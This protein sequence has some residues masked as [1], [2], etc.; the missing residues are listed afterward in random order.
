MAEKMEVQG[1]STGPVISRV[2][3]QFFI[4]VMIWA[5]LLFWS[6]GTLKWVRGWI[7]LGLLVATLLVNFFVLLKKNPT[8][9]ETRTKKQRFKLKFDILLMLLVMTPATM[10]VPIVAGLDAVRYRLLP[11]P[12]WAVFPGIALHIAGDA[13]MLWAM[14]VNPFMEKAIRIQTERGH[15]VIMT[16]PY[17]IV[18][19]PM[20]TGLMLLLLAMPLMLGSL[21]TFVP[22][23]IALA[24][25]IVRTILEDHILRKDL[26]GYKEYIKK[27]HYRLL[28]GIW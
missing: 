16:G 25:L 2:A 11:I 4:S 26:P 22:V 17:A 9:L 10:A 23:G 21:W 15:H 8:L 19:H 14:A 6:A 7:H 13:L 3:F 20:Y 18:R 1:K 27:I 5:G 12:F 28:P 24:G